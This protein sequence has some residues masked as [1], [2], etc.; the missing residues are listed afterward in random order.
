MQNKFQPRNTGVMPAKWLCMLNELL[1]I[2]K[3]IQTSRAAISLTH[4]MQDRWNK[5]RI[6]S[7]YFHWRGFILSAG[8]LHKTLFCV[9]CHIK[10]FSA[11]LPKNGDTEKTHTKQEQNKNKKTKLK[12]KK[13]YRGEKVT[14]LYFQELYFQNCPLGGTVGP[15][16]LNWQTGQDL[17]VGSK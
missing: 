14:S 9:L 16:Y 12:W 11:Q 15:F 5:V 10:V 1:H 2:F 17:A 8:N 7:K 13:S 3:S 4:N 6:L